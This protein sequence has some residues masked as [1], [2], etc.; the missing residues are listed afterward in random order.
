MS[1]PDFIIIGAM[2]CGTSTLHAQLAAQN[3][4]FMSEPK[5]PNFFSDDDVYA[6]GLD[7]YKGLFAGAVDGAI[8]GESSTHY[9]KRPT[10]PDCVDRLAAALPGARFIYM[11]RHPLE[12]LVSH[13][14][15]EWTMG[16]VNGSISEALQTRGEFVDYSRY[17]YQLEP[18][19]ERYGRKKLLPVF[20]ERMKTDPDRELS[21]IASFLGAPDAL[22]WRDDLGAQNTS[23]ER[24]RRIPFAA[25]LKDNPP[26]RFLR[27]R[28]LPSALRD[29]MKAGLQMRER[30][31]LS[32]DDLRRVKPALDEDLGRL[33]AVMGVSLN[34]D[35]YHEAMNGP[36]LEWAA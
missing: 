15:H 3:G 2:K 32:Q 10:Y 26:A 6:K 21:R 34:C 25:V 16:T 9:A 5:E 12:R 28:L 29:R 18:Y 24:T 30:P 23:A 22:R 11:M 13:Y 20:F 33:G 36:S 7:W 19:L 8:K 4:F 35:N 14:I 17:A 1:L 31:A 27:R